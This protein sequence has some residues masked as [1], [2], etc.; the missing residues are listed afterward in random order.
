MISASELDA[1]GKEYTLP[2]PNAWLKTALGDSDATA[3]GDGAID[4]RI[5]KSGSDVVVHGKAKADVQVPCA[6]CLEPVKV[7][8]HPEISVLMVPASKIKHER[9]H[10]M[11]SSEA[12]VLPY[13]GDN[14]VLDDLVRDDLLLEIPMIPLC[15]EDCPGIAS[16]HPK[17]E[18]KPVDPRL[19]PLLRLKKE[20]KE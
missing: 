8:L 19:A 14:V 4:V 20:K 13:D 12:D 5:S 10:E 17:E 18:S 7:T 11:A 9:E 16:P 6:R 3:Q 2:I 1:G 15:S